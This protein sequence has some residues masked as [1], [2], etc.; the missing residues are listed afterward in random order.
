MQNPNEESPGS[1]KKPENNGKDG[2]E[3]YDVKAPVNQQANHRRSQNKNASGFS[4]T[5]EWVCQAYIILVSDIKISLSKLLKFTIFN[6][7]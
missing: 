5:S 6:S 4:A 7:R 3:P 2:D 1:S